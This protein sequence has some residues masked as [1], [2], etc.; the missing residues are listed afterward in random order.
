MGFFSN[1]FGGGAAKAAKEA[2][3]IQS[4]SAKR[5]EGLARD[6]TDLSLEDLDKA[7]SGA[8]GEYDAASGALKPYSEAGTSA[9]SRLMAGMGLSGGDARDEFIQGFKTSPGYEFA[10]DEGVGALDR[11]AAARGSLYSGAQGKALTQFG[12]GLANQEYGSY[13]DRLKD[14]VSGGQSAAAGQANIGGQRATSILGTGADRAN[15]RLGGLNAV[16][17]AVTEQGQA[18]AGGVIGAANA[19]AQGMNNLLSLIGGGV[20]LGLGFL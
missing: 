14:L 5:V 11:S 12:Q 8:L 1:L 13:L 10:M 2:A 3:N 20:K 18:Q 4:E 15:V 9:L 6:W 17:N 19:K 16:S 7:L